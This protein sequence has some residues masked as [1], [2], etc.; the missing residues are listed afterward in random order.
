MGVPPTPELHDGQM[1]G[2]TP[3]Q[4]PGGQ[5]ITTMGVKALLEKQIGAQ[6]VDVLGAEASLPD[7]I[8]AVFASAAGSFDDRTQ[9][10]L[11]RMLAAVTRNNPE[12]PLVFFCGGSECWMSYNAAL[13]AIALGYRNVL[14]YRG[15]LEAWRHAGLPLAR[16]A[17]AG[18]G[19]GYDRG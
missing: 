17:G 12:T 9:D 16:R 1:H 6:M 13:R 7:A 8:P 2:P 3:N 19:N 14:W 4:I 10:K 15:G 5:V 18:A 11:A